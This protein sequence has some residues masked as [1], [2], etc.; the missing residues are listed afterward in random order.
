[1]SNQSY[2]KRHKDMKVNK[3]VDSN[4]QQEASLCI[5]HFPLLVV[6]LIISFIIIF[7]FFCCCLFCLFV[8]LIFFTVNP[9]LHSGVETTEI[10]DMIQEGSTFCPLFDYE[11]Q[12]Y[13]RFD[14]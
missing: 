5:L 3:A 2:G 11:F 1:M 14:Y 4:G 9:V 13:P 10:H 8:C 12:P 7:R 6:S